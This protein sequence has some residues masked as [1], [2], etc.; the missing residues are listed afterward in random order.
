MSLLANDLRLSIRRL[1]RSPGFALVAVTTLAL[2]IGANTSIFSVVDAALIQPLPYPTADR[3]VRVFSPSLKGPSTVSPPDFLDWR[4]DN[5]V[6]D[7]MGAWADGSYALTGNGTAEEL[8]AASVTQDFF[9]VLRRTPEL[10]RTFTADDEVSGVHVVVLSDGLWRRRFGA[11]SGLVGRSILLDAVPYTVI[12]VMPSDF[13]YPAGDLLWTPQQFT[14]HDLATQRGAHYLSVIARLRPGATLDGAQTEMQTIWTRLARAFPTKDSDRGGQVV[15]LRRSIVGPTEPALLVLWA[16]VGVVLLIA[17]ANVANL[18][19]ARAVTRQREMAIRSALG[20]SR[21]DLMRASIADAVLLALLGGA[22]GVGLASWGVRALIAIRPDDTSNIAGATLDLRVLLVS[23]VISIGA[24]LAA[25]LLPSLQIKPRRDVQR[26]KRVLAI[27]ELALAVILLTSAGLL[28]RTFA[29]LR[30]VDLG[31]Q[32]DNRVTFDVALPDARYE[33]R[34]KRAA[35]LVA[36]TNALRALPG[37]HS[38][39]ATTGLPLSGYGYSMSAYALDGVHL[40]D[41]EQDRLSSQLRVATPAYFAT[42]GIPLKSGRWFT[43]ADRLET[44]P[45]A[46]V[47]EAAAKLIAPGKS[48]IGHS[49]TLGTTFGLG[50]NRVGGTIVGVVGN[51]HERADLTRP[52]PPMIYLAHAQFPLDYW[53]IVASTASPSIAPMR[54]ALEALDPDVPLFHPSTMAHLADE[55]VSRPRFVMLLLEI[56]ATVAITMAM[57]G[58]YGVIAYSVGERTREIGVRMALGARTE[59]VLALVIKDGIATGTIGVAIGL[60]GSLAATKLLQGLLFGVGT[61]DLLTLGVTCVLV[62]VATLAATWL[63]AWRASHIDPV[64]AIKSD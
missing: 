9:R 37:V 13:D 34:E 49:I 32:T 6:F 39:G 45:V 38:V 11:D 42:M 19:L 5:T 12:G 56:F 2:G 59:Q 41:D 30:S 35:F 16:A 18:L 60:V 8:D 7:G 28:L 55:A 44:Q 26:A 40:S 46:V 14:S 25:G 58:L 61:T 53:S 51:T 47:N 3:V 27:A 33:S 17:C 43:D 24:G 36:L 57:V 20:A 63:P 21:G 15:S 1:L 4:A 52:V 23:L 62:G 10:G 54:A 31:Y 50:D 64:V 48:A 22:A 29:A